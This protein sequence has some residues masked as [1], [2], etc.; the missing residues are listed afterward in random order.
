[1]DIAPT[2]LYLVGAP[3]ALDMEGVVLVDLLD[4]SWRAAHPVRY[5]RTYG[6]REV[7]EH[8]AIATDADDRIRE[9]LR[10]LGY[11]N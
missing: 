1:V 6:T 3:A 8:S 9:E 2:V 5:V 4:A 7:V 11:I 10:A